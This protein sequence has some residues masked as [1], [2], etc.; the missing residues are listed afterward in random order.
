L[1]IEDDSTMLRGLKDNFEFKGYRVKIARDGKWGLK[2]AMAEDTDLVILD[3]MLPN[4]NGYEVCSNLRKKKLDVPIIM[5]SAKGE[6][7]DVILGFNLGADDY[8]TKPF[9]VQELLARVEAIMRRRRK[10]EPAF[11]EFGNC[12]LDVP[13]CTLR[14][15]GKEVNLTPGEFKILQLFLRK[16][17]CVLSRSEIRDAVWGYCRFITLRDVDAIIITLRSKVEEDPNN[18]TFIHMVQSIGYRFESSG[19]HGNDP[20]N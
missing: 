11:Y 14:R 16:G 13:G 15:D 1:I 3:I 6:E 4:M 10:V 7:S 5:L 18:P 9:S 8:V 19:P 17:G 2:A 20:D 12:R